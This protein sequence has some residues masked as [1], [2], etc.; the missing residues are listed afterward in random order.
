VSDSF[1]ILVGCA[2]FVIGVGL[3]M[4]LGATHL[5]PLPKGKPVSEQRYRKLWVVD[6]LLERERQHPTLYPYPDERTRR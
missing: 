3:G 1:G 6:P 4:F 5:R 2:G